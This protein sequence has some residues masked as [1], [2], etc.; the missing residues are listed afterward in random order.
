MRSVFR[1]VIYTPNLA[2]RSFFNPTLRVSGD[3]RD[4]NTWG[5]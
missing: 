4:F 2:S 5:G 1:T 3:T